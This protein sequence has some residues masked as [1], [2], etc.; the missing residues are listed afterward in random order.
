MSEQQQPEPFVKNAASK[1]QVE[2]AEAKER[3]LFDQ[4]RNDLL[5]VMATPQGRRFLWRLLAKC[6]AFSSVFETSAR[7]HY[8]SGRQD[9]AFDLLREIDAADPDMFFK[10]RTENLNKE[11]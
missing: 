9:V 6:N 5:A 10:M 4:R 3:R 8:N 2:S 11:I 7:I 1:K